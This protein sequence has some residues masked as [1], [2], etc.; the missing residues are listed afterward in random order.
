LEFKRTHLAIYLSRS[1]NSVY[2]FGG[3]GDTGWRKRRVMRSR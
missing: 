1:D 3:L 2:R